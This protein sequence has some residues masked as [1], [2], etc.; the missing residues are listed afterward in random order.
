MRGSLTNTPIVLGL[1]VLPVSTSGNGL[2]SPAV[3]TA[4]DTRVGS[5]D[6]IKHVLKPS[7]NDNWSGEAGEELRTASTNLAYLGT[8]VSAY[9][10]ATKASGV[11]PIKSTVLS[12]CSNTFLIFAGKLA[13]DDATGAVT[14]PSDDIS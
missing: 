9:Q 8:D 2:S 3:A 1:R 14:P 5:M 11:R 10:S 4:L 12:N 7:P 13:V 6:E